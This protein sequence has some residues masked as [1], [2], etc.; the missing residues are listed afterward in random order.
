MQVFQDGSIMSCDKWKATIIDG[1]L[2]SMLYKQ[3]REEMVPL[4]AIGFSGIS[5]ARMR[6]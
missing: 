2:N 6:R 1:K 5:I 4:N 3:L